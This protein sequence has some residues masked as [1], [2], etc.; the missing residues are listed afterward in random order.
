VFAV[1][2][3]CSILTWNA[4][5]QIRRTELLTEEL[6]GVKPEEV[7]TVE[8]ERDTAASS[9]SFAPKPARTSG[10]SSNRSACPQ[11]GQ[12]CRLSSRADEGQAAA[13]SELTSTPPFTGSNPRA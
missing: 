2:V 6:A 11:R 12:L 7:D 10:T 1:V 5:G 3:C 13:S 9:R 8:M 4:G